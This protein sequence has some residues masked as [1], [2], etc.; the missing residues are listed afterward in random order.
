MAPISVRAEDEKR[1]G[2]NRV[3]GMAVA[4]GTHVDDPIARLHNVHQGAVESKAL[5]NAIGARLMTDYS[6]FIPSARLVS[7]YGMGPV[8]D[9]IGLIHPVF[10]LLRADHDR[11]HRLPRDDAGPRLLRRMP[12]GLLRRDARRGDRIAAGGETV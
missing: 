12:A 4:I 5:V 2:G 9:G 6:Q 1:K 3:S 10:Q 11:R 8:G 7:Q